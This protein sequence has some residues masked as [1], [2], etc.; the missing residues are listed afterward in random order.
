MKRTRTLNNFK[1][2]KQ[3]E[4]MQYNSNTIKT[5][6]SIKYTIDEAFHFII[7]DFPEF[8]LLYIVLTALGDL[9]ISKTKV[10]SVRRIGKI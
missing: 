2:R 7:P 9:N 3:A 5:F 4:F 6:K 1:I 8:L 10:L